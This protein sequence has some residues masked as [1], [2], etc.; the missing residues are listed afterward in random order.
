MLQEGNAHYVAGLLKH[1]HQDKA[2]RALTATKGQTPF[3]TILSCSDS[4]A[5]VELIFDQGVG[6]LFVV[7]VAGNVAGEDE[8]AS[9][10]YA[11]DHLGTPV[12]VV[13]GHTKCGAVT[14]VVEDAHLHGSMPA[15]AAKIKPAVARAKAEQP[16]LNGAPLVAAAVKANIYQAVADLF[17]KSQIIQDLVKAGKVKVMGAL[18]DLESGKVSW[19]GPHPEEKRLLAGPAGAK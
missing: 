10:E 4:R 13:L 19:L 3:A 11:G 2:R 14:A 8:I 9:L 1:P 7:R 18:Y 16:G 12:L 5:P 17:A 15:L 6:D